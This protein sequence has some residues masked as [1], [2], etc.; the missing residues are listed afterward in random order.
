MA[1]DLLNIISIIFTFCLT[2]YITLPQKSF[3][4][5]T[6]LIIWDSSNQEGRDLDLSILLRTT[7][8]RVN[9][10]NALFVLDIT[11]NRYHLRD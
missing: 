11:K 8:R 4:L 5:A 6:L 10:S 9:E 3:P 1:Y 7:K 2:Q